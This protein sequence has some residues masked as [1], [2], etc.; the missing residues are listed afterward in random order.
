MPDLA[1][2]LDLVIRLLS[3]FIFVHVILSWIPGIR[4]D[5]PVARAVH[6]VVAPILNPIRRLMPPAGGLDLSP[7]VAI[8]LLY[9]VR[10]LLGEVLQGF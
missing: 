4:P 10:T 5:H 2:L 6:Q 1:E 9:L 3:L 7:I 8:M